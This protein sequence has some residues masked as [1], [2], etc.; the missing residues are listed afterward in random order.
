MWRDPADR[1]MRF[2][3]VYS[4]GPNARWEMGNGDDLVPKL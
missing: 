1:L 2:F 3:E 4:S